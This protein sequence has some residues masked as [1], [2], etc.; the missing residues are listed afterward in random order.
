[1]ATPIR[2][3]IS[4][5]SGHSP[6][7]PLLA[8][9]TGSWLAREARAKAHGLA[10]LAIGVIALALSIAASDA[11]GARRSGSHSVPPAPAAR[12]LPYPQLELPVQIAGTQYAPV[13]W[14]DIAGWSAD[15]HLAASKP[16]RPSGA[17]NAPRP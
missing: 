13:A 12:Q 5:M 1:M 11:L 16:F 15:D 6:A 4:P 17:P 3:P 8:I 9:R 14:S 7:T 2:S 10:G